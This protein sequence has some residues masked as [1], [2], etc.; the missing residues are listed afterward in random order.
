MLLQKDH[1]KYSVAQEHVASTKVGL[2]AS[3]LGGGEVL[4]GKR[5]G[6]WQSSLRDALNGDELELGPFKSQLG[7][8]N[9]SKGLSLPLQL[10]FDAEAYRSTLHP[11]MVSLAE[12]LIANLDARFPKDLWA[13]RKAR[14]ATPTRRTSSSARGSPS[15]CRALSSMS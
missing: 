7:A 12:E 2:R 4:G 10:P 1:I 5:L 6:E 15:S 3:Y 13:S 11:E 8:L 14:N 9:S